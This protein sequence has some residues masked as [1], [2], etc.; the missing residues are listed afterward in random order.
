MSA[1]GT[2]NAYCYPPLRVLI[3]IA[4]CECLRLLILLLPIV[5]AYCYGPSILHITDAYIA[6]GYC[7]LLLPTAS[8]Y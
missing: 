2:A 7:L 8:A 6:Y 1:S 5:F 3:A 4:D